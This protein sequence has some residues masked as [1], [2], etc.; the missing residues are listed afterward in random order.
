MLGSAVGFPSEFLA[1]GVVVRSPDAGS[2][3]RAASVDRPTTDATTPL[4]VL[5]DADSASAADVVASALPDAGRAFLF[6]DR[7][8]GTGTGLTG[9][10]LDAMV[11]SMSSGRLSG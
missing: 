10:S 7:T 2:V 3:V 8:A 1:S 9:F 6:G 5:I 4:V 11:R